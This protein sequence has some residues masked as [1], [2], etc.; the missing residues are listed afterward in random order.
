MTMA[1]HPDAN[2]LPQRKEK[3]QNIPEKK[4]YQ[5]LVHSVFRPVPNVSP[6]CTP[7]NTRRD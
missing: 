5:C 3:N 1:F 4:V 2:A 7:P 6:N